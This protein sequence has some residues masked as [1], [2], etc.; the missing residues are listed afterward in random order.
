MTEPPYRLARKVRRLR[1]PALYCIA[2]DDEVNPPELAE[3]SARNVASAELR[4][5]SGGHFSP[6]IGETFERVVADQVGFLQR[7]L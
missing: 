1:C 6:F 4:L 2:V 3:R 7:K 5:Y